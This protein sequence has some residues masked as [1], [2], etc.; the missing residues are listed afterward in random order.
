MIGSIIKTNHLEVFAYSRKKKKRNVKFVLQILPSSLTF[1]S[2]LQIPLFEG[3][4]VK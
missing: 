1:V 2:I 3:V 4:I